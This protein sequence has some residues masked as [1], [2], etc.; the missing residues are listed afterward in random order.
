MNGNA[1]GLREIMERILPGSHCHGCHR[2]NAWNGY[3][4]NNRMKYLMK[5]R[6]NRIQWVIV[7]DSTG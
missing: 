4:G 5:P 1:F 3:E 6:K 7:V 2:T